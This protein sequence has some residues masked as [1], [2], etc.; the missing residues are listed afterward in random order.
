MPRIQLKIIG[1][2]AALVIAVV[3]I[4]GVLAERGLRARLTQDIGHSLE[5]QAGLVALRV[6][7]GW[8][9]E[10]GPPALKRVADASARATGARITLIARGGRVVADSEIAS[11]MLAGVDN[12][13][14]RPEVA[15]ALGGGVGRSMRRSDTVKREL[16]YVAVPAHPDF[17]SASDS[18]SGDVAVVR[19]AIGLDRVEAAVA[20]LRAQLF[21]AA[22]L[23]LLAALAL[24]FALSLLSLRPIRE[25][26]EVVGDM[27]DGK[28][29]RHLHWAVHDERAEI[30]TSINR[31]AQQLREQIAGA[32]REK[33]QLEAVVASMAE[34]VL[35]VDREARILLANPRFREL[36]SVWGEVVGRS[37]PEVIRIPEIEQALREAGE[38]GEIDVREIG[39]RDSSD[40][41]LLMHSAVFP[42]GGPRSGSVF[43]FHDVTALRR[44]DRVRR[45]FIANASHELRTPLTAIQGFADTLASGDLAPSEA[46]GYLDVIVRNAR[47]MSDLIDDLLTLSRIEGEGSQLEARPIDIE[48]LARTVMEDFSPRFEQAS[49]EGHLH[50]EGRLLCRGDRD[51]IEQILSNLLGNAARYTNPGGRVDVEISRAQGGVQ[52]SVADSGIGIPQRDL[53]R[54]FE[55]FYRVDAARSRALGST[56]LGLSIVKHLVGHMGGEI[57]VESELGKGSRFTLT[58]PAA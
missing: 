46:R 8:R 2:L 15:S 54:I 31:M 35:V 33:E 30:A 51:A 17:D 18:T 19:L 23:G 58:L 6:S 47:R 36:F 1:G 10:A 5:Q 12:H 21:T 48:R 24:S 43:V 44:V 37:I 49:L 25:L 39:L 55:R 9:G 50:S 41:I 14:S 27:A 16:V 26:R 4:T 34:G 52:L 32:T 28:L 20:K 53:E 57:R 7:D 13:A 29:G 42:T 38:A 40:R 11:A 3:A 45:D 56:G 22:A